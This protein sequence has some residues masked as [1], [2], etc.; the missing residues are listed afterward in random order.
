LVLDAKLIF[1]G[2]NDRRKA[3][4]N[5]ENRWGMGGYGEKRYFQIAVSFYPTV[6][7]RKTCLSL[8]KGKS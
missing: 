2:V 6:S 1:N 3:L 7:P 8:F 5:L 4:T